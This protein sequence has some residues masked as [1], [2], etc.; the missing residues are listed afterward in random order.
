[1]NMC[2]LCNKSTYWGEE[3]KRREKTM[4]TTAGQNEMSGVSEGGEWMSERAN[5][6]H[7][8]H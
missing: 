1:M 4:A 5:Y 3:A 2:I 8:V 7:F 6:I